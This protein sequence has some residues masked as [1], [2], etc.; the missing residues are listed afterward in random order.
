MATV[1]PRVAVTLNAEA[2]E[3]VRYLAL[4]TG[5]SM[6]SVI[7]ELVHTVAP[8]LTRTA[9]VV[10][11]ANRA[12]ETQREGLRSAVAEAQ[13]RVGHLRFEYEAMGER[14]LSLLEAAIEATVAREREGDAQGGASHGTPRRPDEEGGPDRMTSE[15][16][17]VARPLAPAA[18]AAKGL[19][20]GAAK[21]SRG[22]GSRAATSRGT[23]RK[24]AKG[25]DPRAS[26]TGVRS[27]KKGRKKG[28]ASRASV[29]LKRKGSGA[30]S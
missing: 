16:A 15:A 26:N 7:A 2:H 3:A 9:E 13:K 20:R 10:A 21:A 1:R 4:A 19:A 18:A 8:V 28:V 22:R 11:A 14:Q 24:G 17:A 25:P 29:K 30:R 27:P 23:G 12:R 6:S 5:S